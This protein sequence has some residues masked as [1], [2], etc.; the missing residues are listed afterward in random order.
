MQGTNPSGAFMPTDAKVMDPTSYK[1]QGID[2]SF[3]AMGR[4]A[5]K[6][7]AQAWPRVFGQALQV[8]LAPGHFYNGTSLTEKGTRTTGNATSSNPTLASVGNT[9]GVEIGMACMV[10]GFAA[11]NFT[12]TTA[13]S[14]TV[15]SV[16]SFTGL[17]VG[18]SIYSVNPA[19]IP[20]GTTI[21]DLNPG[22]GTLTLSQA[23]LLSVSNASL[24]SSGMQPCVPIGTAVIGTTSNSI[25]LSQNA[26]ATLVGATIVVGHAL[27]SVLT[28]T[29]N[30]TAVVTGIPSTNGWYPNMNITGTGI[31]VNTTISSVD[32]A[33]QIT[34]SAAATI[35]GTSL[36]TVSIPP[37]AGG[38]NLRVDYISI[39]QTTGVINWTQGAPSATPVTPALPAGTLPIA[40]TK[41]ANADITIAASGIADVRD[42]AGLGLGSGAYGSSVSMV[43]PGLALA[44]N[45]GGS[46]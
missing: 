11:A 46:M 10:Y 1:V 24:I 7:Q 43:N 9:V 37:P 14:T 35:N 38:S 23:A 32:S 41:I 8:M 30:S 33:T 28:G 26:S 2:A 17:F 44:Y 15:T 5:S 40:L 36:L 4:E 16:S 25:T 27:G 39:N 45:A 12:G 31:P 3:S 18:M 13:A 6:Y 42:L 21:T 20:A 34:L 22:A 29:L 19:N